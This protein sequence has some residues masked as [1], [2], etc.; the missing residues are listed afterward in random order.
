MDVLV[1]TS[2][3]FTAKTVSWNCPTIKLKI[4][5]SVCLSIKSFLQ[6]RDFAWIIVKKWSQEVQKLKRIYRTAVCVCITYSLFMSL[7]L[8]VSLMS[9]VAMPSNT[10]DFRVWWLHTRNESLLNGVTILTKQTVQFIHATH[11]Y[12]WKKEWCLAS[13]TFY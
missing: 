9:S 10:S 2:M 6:H 5:P 3:H 13:P 4:I 11:L 8:S 1:L 12:F 7:A